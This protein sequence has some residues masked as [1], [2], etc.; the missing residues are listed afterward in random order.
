MMNCGSKL[1]PL[2]LDGWLEFNRR[3]WNLEPRVMEFK[4][5]NK[6]LPLLKTVL[7]FDKK[8]HVKMPPRNPYLPV[9]FSSTPTE[10]LSR[11]GRQWLALSGMLAEEMYRAGVRG[12]ISFSPNVAD[13]RAFQWR[14][15]HVGVRYTFYLDTP[16]DEKQT[17]HVVRN[18]IKKASKNGF[19]YSQA[20]SPEEVI[21]CL[22]DT[23]DRQ[24]FSHGLSVEDIRMAE[25]LLGAEHFR[26]YGC[27]APSGE[28]ASARISLHCSENR[29]IGWVAGTKREFLNS[30]ATQALIAFA[31]EDLASAGAAGFDFAG[32]N[33]ANVA[34]AK[35]TWGGP[36]V[37]FYTVSAPSIRGMIKYALDIRKY[38]RGVSG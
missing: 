30:G 12:T 27:Y 33:I 17:D 22:A 34:A 18:R 38:R 28:I 8:G 11:L 5:D 13:L 1:S 16:V 24:G 2:F 32:A 7:Y 25:E 10:S 36:L 19:T 9:E 14:G 3:K 4:E 26:S 23:E 37:P 31:L 20:A 35:A 29:A 6:E 21:E 15:F